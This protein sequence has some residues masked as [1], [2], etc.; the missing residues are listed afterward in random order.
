[1]PP[2]MIAAIT[3]MEVKDKNNLF[4]LDHVLDKATHPLA[5]LSL[6]NFVPC[7]YSCN[8][9]FKRSEKLVLNNPSISPTSKHFSFTQSVRFKLFFPGTFKRTYKD[10]KKVDDFVLNFEI[11]RDKDDYENYLRIFRLR[12]RY[13]FHKRE[14]LNLVNLRKPYSDSQIKEI[15]KI[16]RKTSLEVKK[17]IFGKELFEAVTENK[18][19]TKLRKDIAIDM[20]IKD[21]VP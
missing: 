10:I 15:A 7:C 8:S 14:V 6:F 11:D 3:N 19:L 18:P 5:A 17:D 2:R 13:V 16:T 9:K 21:V 4:T 1:M 12:A 20:G